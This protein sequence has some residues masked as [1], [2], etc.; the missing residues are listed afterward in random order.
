MI[1]QNKTT[2]KRKKELKKP[3]MF[4]WQ[5]CQL[6]AIHEI[7]KVKISEIIR[8]KKKY[9]GFVPFLSAAIY[10]HAKLPLDGTD[11]FDK[12]TLNEGRP[13]LLNERD[14]RLIK[15]QINIL[16]EFEE[17]FSSRRIQLLSIGNRVNNSALRRG[18]RKLECR[19]RRTRKK[20]LL[21]KSDETNR[22]KYTKRIKRLKVGLEFW[23]K[24]I[25]FYLDATIFEYKRN[26][27]SKPVLPRHEIGDW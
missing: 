7:G 8:D 21:T 9:P 14:Y 16:R 5:S 6:R 27:M 2:K 1:S 22:L 3:Q 4:Y 25:S 19:H 12:R 13:P 10:R 20:E 17:S 15:R 11:V 18:L 23:T 24:G 26:L